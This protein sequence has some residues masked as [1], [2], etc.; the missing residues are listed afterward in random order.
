MLEVVSEI[1]Y[2]GIIID[3]NLN[4]SAHVNYI[5][6][7]VGAKLG[8]MRRIG[9]DLSPRMRCVVYKAI[10]AP[11][12]EYCASILVGISKTNLQHLQK[13]QNQG[14][15]IILRCNRRV[16]ISDMLEALHF[17]SIKERIE[18]NVCLLV[19]KIINGMCPRYLCNKLESVQYEGAVNTRQRGNIYIDRCR[20]R[21][22][23]KMLLHDGIKMYNSLPNEIKREQ[24]IQS[25]RRMLSQHIKRRER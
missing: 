7:K 1:K 19:F 22:E 23:Q 12:F 18:Y 11:L 8:V 24:R 3:R 10:I 6:K 20:T 25:F 5:S 16:R 21:E 4:F 13:L 14:M 9:V 2:L 15:R 17:I